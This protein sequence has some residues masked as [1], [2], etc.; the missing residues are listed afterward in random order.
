MDSDWLSDDEIRNLLGNAKQLGNYVSK[1][2]LR[3]ANSQCDFLV[4]VRDHD[5]WQVDGGGWN[6]ANAPPGPDDTSR[7]VLN[8]YDETTWSK[9][10]VPEASLIESVAWHDD[11][12]IFNCSNRTIRATA[13]QIW[14][15]I[16][17]SMT[18]RALSE[19]EIEFNFGKL[20]GSSPLKYHT[21]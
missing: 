4:L 8:Y 3:A 21:A 18:G 16:Q 6:D 1:S 14:L 20:D 12:F 9:M 15:A 7:Q 5:A 17:D 2:P 13:R 10:Y 11:V 19:D